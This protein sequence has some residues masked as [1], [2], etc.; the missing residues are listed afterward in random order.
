MSATTT[1]PERVVKAGDRCFERSP[2]DVCR[3]YSYCIA[4]IGFEGYADRLSRLDR[5]A[6][7]GQRG[8]LLPSLCGT[9]SEHTF[10]AV[11]SA[12]K[13]CR[14]LNVF[15]LLVSSLPGGSRIWCEFSQGFARATL[16]PIGLLSLGLQ[17]AMRCF[18]RVYFGDRL[19]DALSLPPAPIP[20]HAPF[21]DCWLWLFRRR[22][23]PRSIGRGWRHNTQRHTPALSSAWQEWRHTIL[24][25]L[26]SFLTASA[27]LQCDPAC[28]VSP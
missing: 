26:C 7:H 15:P 16:S 18:W 4:D 5:A 12:N 8:S 20:G 22:I 28:M 1:R 21:L 14:K 11:N 19:I 25:R 27:A 9:K 10:Y 17:C 24:G 23:A 2:A 13:V 3:P 6:S